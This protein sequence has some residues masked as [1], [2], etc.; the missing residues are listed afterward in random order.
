MYG[1]NPFPGTD[2]VG[3][4]QLFCL[5]WLYLGLSYPFLWETP[6]MTHLLFQSCYMLRWADEPGLE[7]QIPLL[8]F[9]PPGRIPKHNCCSSSGTTA[10]IF[11][12]ICFNLLFFFFK[13]FLKKFY[14]IF[15]L[16]VIVLVL[17]NIKM[18]LPQVYMCSPS[19]TLL[20]SPS[21]YLNLLFNF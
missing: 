15:K 16:Y 8:S 19:W 20:P 1:S 10:G 12:F 4:S 13:W 14:F 2:W 9:L 6:K 3:L 17:S 21:P 5:A 18:N 7:P 11:L